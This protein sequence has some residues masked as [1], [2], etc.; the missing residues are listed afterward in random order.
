MYLYFAV[1][2]VTFNSEQ[3]LTCTFHNSIGQNLAAISNFSYFWQVLFK[4]LIADSFTIELF[5]MTQILRGVFTHRIN[6]RDISL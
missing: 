6:F 3:F 5:L 1:H 2:K 4:F